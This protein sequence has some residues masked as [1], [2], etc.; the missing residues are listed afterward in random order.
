MNARA[1]CPF[2]CTD[3]ATAT[4]SINTT[5]QTLTN[6]IVAGSTYGS[7]AI[8]S[9]TGNVVVT[10]V[11]ATANFWQLTSANTF[12]GTMD[13]RT[14]ATVFATVNNAVANSSI[15]TIDTGGAFN[16]GATSQTL[17]NLSGGGGIITASGGVLTETGAASYSGNV[18]GGGSIVIAGTTILSGVNTFTGATTVQNGGVLNTI[19]NNALADS[20]AVTIATGGTLIIGNATNQTINNLS[21]GGNIIT[22]VSNTRGTLTENGTGNFSGVISG[23]GSLVTTGTGNLMLSGVN[24][25]TGSTTVGSGTTLTLGVAGAIAQSSGVAN[26]GTI[27]IGTTSQTLNNLEGAGNI[28]TGSGSSITANNTGDNTFTGAISGG[29]NMVITG[30]GFLRLDGT[31]T[32]TGTTEVSNSAT[33]IFF[34]G[35]FT[36]NITVDSGGVLTGAGS[37]TGSLTNNGNLEGPSTAASLTTASYS[38]SAGGTFNVIFDDSASNKLVVTTGGAALNGAVNYFALIPANK[39]VRGT[40][41]TLIDNSAGTGIT[42][43]FTK[44][45]DGTPMA[46]TNIVTSD[47][48]INL[49]S[50]AMKTIYN[51]DTVLARIERAE[52]FADSG[53]TNSEKATGT[54]LDTLQLTTVDGSDMDTVLNEISA[55]PT[56]DQAAALD[57]LS[58]ALNASVPT[59]F[60]DGQRAFDGMLAKRLGGDCNS[61]N[62]SPVSSGFTPASSYYGGQRYYPVAYNAVPGRG[63][64][65]WACGYGNFGQ[66][67]GDAST[68]NVKTSGTGGAFGMELTP[69]PRMQVRA[70]MGFSNNTLEANSDKATLNSYQAGLYGQLTGQHVYAGLGASGAY[71]TGDT[72]RHVI[73]GGLNR[74]ANGDINGYTM[75]ANGTAG[76]FRNFGRIKAELGATVEYIYTNQDAYTESGGGA[77][78]LDVGSQTL[79]SLRTSLAAQMNTSIPL[80]GATVLTPE[81]RAGIFN[82]AMDVTP[83]AHQGFT[84]TG[85]SFTVNGPNPGRTGFEGGLGATV[86]F[87]RLSLFGDY[88]GTFKNHETSHM[89]VGGMK[90]KW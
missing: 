4:G 17:H 23:P 64:A 16:F 41:F 8:I 82:D 50:I 14:G 15:V 90:L 48:D 74:A 3:L 86:N 10:D 69:G 28:T 70:G 20:T 53:I 32:Y 44:A 45:S 89:I 37:T 52:F 76:I 2:D 58:G 36:S 30:P 35:S 29:A 39:Y 85:T 43:T 66:V 77:I 55:L 62:D 84:G 21:G 22:G 42:G 56:V 68:A 87:R 25:Y 18:S 65:A 26:A 11:G 24:T 79:N 51:S 47:Q 83:S 78:D 59:G 67:D 81:V 12:S 54:A 88:N 6:D 9:G 40:T 63:R 46:A 72:T 34:T 31:N 27:A 13:I 49:G 80:G 38:Q 61:M 5:G 75:A 73:F 60:R 71:N 57:Q 19:V 33:L 7:G 1:A